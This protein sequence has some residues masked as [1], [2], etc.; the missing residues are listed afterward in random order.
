MVQSAFAIMH[1]QG[2]VPRSI[3]AGW[4]YVFESGL[5]TV[6]VQIAGLIRGTGRTTSGFSKDGKSLRKGLRQDTVGQS[7]EV[8]A[9]LGRPSLALRSP[10]GPLRVPG[11]LRAKAERYAWAEGPVWTAGEPGSERLQET[12]YG[13]FENHRD[14]ETHKCRLHKGLG[15]EKGLRITHIGI[16][17][18]RESEA[19]RIPRLT[20]WPVVVP[21][22]GRYEGCI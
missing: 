18:A 3:T 14:S 10:P 19:H 5:R 13:G 21:W 15:Y 7:F 17:N 6:V 12:G 1:G 8:P 22:E 4:W 16:V 9:A 2:T 20:G 11:G